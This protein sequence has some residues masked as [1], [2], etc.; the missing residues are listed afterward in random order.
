M[1]DG[2][3]QI[4]GFLPQKCHILNRYIENNTVSIMKV[5]K[6]QLFHSLEY[7]FNEMYTSEQ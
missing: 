7:F 2:E 6:W 1:E 5:L 4:K 3:M